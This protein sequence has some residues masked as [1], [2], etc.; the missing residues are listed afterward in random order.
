VSAKPENGKVSNLT[1]PTAGVV[2]LLSPVLKPPL[3]AVVPCT[4]PVR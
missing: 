2:S 4:D 1:L 3:V